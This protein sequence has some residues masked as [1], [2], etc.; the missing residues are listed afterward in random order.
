MLL[1]T[2]WLSSIHTICKMRTYQIVGGTLKVTRPEKP[3]K[4]F[5]QSSFHLSFGSFD[6]IWIVTVEILK[7]YLR[8]ARLAMWKAASA[9]TVWAKWPICKFHVILFPFDL[10]HWWLHTK[11]TI[12]FLFFCLWF[13]LAR[14]FPIDLQLKIAFYA[15]CQNE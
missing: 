6:S 13:V 14:W 7:L 2:I 10:S 9:A 8:R 4:K 1:M 5:H 15:W 3:T 12:I 11:H